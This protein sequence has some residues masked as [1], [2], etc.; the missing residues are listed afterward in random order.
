M[1]VA[2]VSIDRLSKY[3]ST[4]RLIL[5]LTHH[6]RFDEIWNYFAYWIP[7]YRPVH[8]QAEDL[9]DPKIL[10]KEFVRIYQIQQIGIHVYSLLTHVSYVDLSTI[11]KDPSF[12][13]QKDMDKHTT[14]RRNLPDAHS[15]SRQLIL[16]FKVN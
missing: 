11:E 4:D 8:H 5:D 7:A 14:S 16:H 2:S 10:M 12:S 13:S 6:G 3:I 9:L 1:T 15:F